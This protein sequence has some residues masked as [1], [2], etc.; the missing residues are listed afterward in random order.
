MC[1]KNHKYISH[2]SKE[3]IS[4]IYRCNSLY[5][6]NCKNLQKITRVHG[7]AEL[8]ISNCPNLT[9]IDEAFGSDTRITNCP[10]LKKITNGEFRLLIVGR[11]DIESI[12]YRKMSYKPYL[13][14]IDCFYI[15]SVPN[16]LNCLDIDNTKLRSRF[17]NLDIC[18]RANNLIVRNVF[19]DV[20]PIRFTG[21]C[22]IIN[23]PDLVV[24][25]DGNVEISEIDDQADE[26]R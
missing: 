9:E 24:I 16:D 19:T 15:S 10:K 12:H 26:I 21:K 8:R 2:S 7:G 5:I 23:C 1:F 18:E 13:A 17:L 3:E 25:P 4:D 22:D 20:I 14:L 6:E 11:C